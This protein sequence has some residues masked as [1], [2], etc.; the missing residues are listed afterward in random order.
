MLS[1]LAANQQRS[2]GESYWLS[3]LCQC[4]MTSP[5]EF[6]CQVSCG[7]CISHFRGQSFTVDN[8]LLPLMFLAVMCRP[9][10]SLANDRSLFDLGR[11]KINTRSPCT[12]AIVILALIACAHMHISLRTQLFHCICR[13]RGEDRVPAA[14]SCC[15]DNMP[16]WC[17]LLI[18][19]EP[20]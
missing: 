3:M 4:F 14:A 20:L 18:V 1:W 5:E 7:S 12:V 16:V 6:D 13:K 15:W 8:L 9:S 11:L 19:K 2:L 17:V 10:G